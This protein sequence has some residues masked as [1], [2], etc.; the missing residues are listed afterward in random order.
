MDYKSLAS[1]P[2]FVGLTAA[3]LTQLAAICQE[4]IATPHEQIIT[5]NT[6]GEEVFI[7]HNGS[8]EVYIEGLE[9]ERVLVV[10]GKGQ[11]FGE[12]ALID[13][14]YRSAS[15]RAGKQ[16]CAL[17]LIHNQAFNGLCQS[18]AHIGYIVMRNLARD[19]AFKLRHQNLAQ[20]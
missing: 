7:I 6:T 13:Q 15:V 1:V 11:V 3:S 17:Y 2:L 20:M 8:V 5:Q 19:L 10:L 18:K 9:Q 4:R 14:G 12:M 16:G